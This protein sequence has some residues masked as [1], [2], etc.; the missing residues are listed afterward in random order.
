MGASA[1]VVD[2]E[3]SSARGNGVAVNALSSTTRVGPKPKRGVN[4]IGS[5]GTSNR[6]NQ[7]NFDLNSMPI[8]DGEV[9]PL[10]EQLE[11]VLD[12][13]GGTDLSEE[14]R[15]HLEAQASAHWHRLL[16]HAV[17]DTEQR[18][19]GSLALSGDVTVTTPTS[20]T[21]SVT[22]GMT[23]TTAAAATASSKYGQSPP[24]VKWDPRSQTYLR[25]T[26]TTTTTTTGGGGSGGVDGYRI[27]YGSDSGADKGKDRARDGVD[28][29]G[30]KASG[31]G[32]GNVK[33]VVLAGEEKS[34]NPNPNPNPDPD[35]D[36]DP[37]PDPDHDPD[38]TANAS[39]KALRNVG[40]KRDINLSFTSRRKRDGVEY[41]KR[42]DFPDGGSSPMSSPGTVSAATE[43]RGGANSFKA[44]A[45][46]EVEERVEIIAG[47]PTMLPA[48]E[49]SLKS[50]T[51]TALTVGWD[52][53]PIVQDALGAIRVIYRKEERS[54]TI[55]SPKS[56][57]S[58][59]GGGGTG[60]SP[61]KGTANKLPVRPL[62]TYEIAF[63]VKVQSRGA[64]ESSTEGEGE[65]EGDEWIIGSPATPLR[66]AT[67]ENLQPNTQY[68]L[69]VRR[70]GL[71]EDFSDFGVPAVIRTGPG[72]PSQP[73]DLVPSEVT[74]QSVMVSWEPPMKD[75]GL[76]VL[77]YVV[78][79]KKWG[80][81]FE[82]VYR[83]KGRVC[84]ST[85]LTPNLVHIFE[86][87]AVNKA[88]LGACG[89]RV[90]VRTLHPGAAD[91]TPW[92]EEVDERT[93]SIYYLHPK[94][95]QVA[96]TLP[97]GSLLDKSESFRSKRSYFQRRARKLIDDACHEL[98]IDDGT[99]SAKLEIPR[100][101]LLLPSLRA[102][103]RFSDDEL[104]CGPIRIKWENE[105]GIDA[106][107]LSKDWF[108]ALAKVVCN[109]TAGLLQPTDGG[110]TVDV[111]A[112][113]I[114][115]F[116]AKWIF[117][118]LGIFLS[119]ALLDTQPLGIQFNPLLLSLMC[120]KTPTMA[121]LEEGD[122]DFFKGLRW[123]LD[124]DVTGAGLSFTANYELFGVTRTVLLTENGP[125]LQDADNEV[126]GE[127][128]T[129]ENKHVYVD[130]LNHWLT[131]GKF[132][133]SLT[134]LLEGFHG[135]SPVDMLVHFSPQEVQTLLGGMP[136]I[137]VNDIKARARYMGGYSDTSPQSA[138]LWKW[139]EQADQELLGRLLAFVTGCATIPVD[140]LNP[141]FT[142]TLS[143]ETPEELA[144]WEV[145][146]ASMSSMGSVLDGTDEDEDGAE[147]KREGPSRMDSLDD[148]EQELN[149]ALYSRDS[150]DDKDDEGK[151]E[152]KGGVKE[153][154]PLMNR[155]HPP[156]ARRKLGTSKVAPLGVLPR[157]HTCF[158]QLVLPPYQTYEQ[159]S[160]QLM[161]ALDHGA[162]GFFLT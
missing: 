36:L 2:K 150:K 161:L 6:P 158:N 28:A 114:H 18:N 84:L 98:G 92:V 75:N 107:G 140:G 13:V 85:G 78:R 144:A 79:M 148:Y 100:S 53:A 160:R 138:W 47:D 46:I 60:G 113:D 38:H 67:I 64:L 146:K 91:M 86:V 27:R 126:D 4:V 102:L 68:V 32:N 122:P 134:H 154:T 80:G 118:C 99:Y 10:Y 41:K 151:G 29:T 149:S 15:R 56:S 127:L 132:E 101:D 59:A 112:G 40:S 22:G 115:G 72:P 65:G 111:R 19:L 108:C 26:A 109:G 131:R 133:P 104:R 87:Y 66:V 17:T 50:R 106:G 51:A 30:D 124:N 129:E 128:V 137:D 20:A 76:P 63:K 14:R 135:V 9:I 120:G 141:P 48:L 33:L 74:S 21:A 49:C 37:D 24:R 90:A 54:S 130:R 153:G 136:S 44:E 155:K 61:T 103:R 31:N 16:V 162:H 95:K 117:R 52:D 110:V 3:T 42:F 25:V 1:S 94:S 97:K 123:V 159:L 55:S 81:F 34:S 43:G 143:M 82:E 69:K 23:P 5:S 71:G 77:E 12:R 89:E 45:E 119:K 116:E 152:S 121:D 83:A 35:P 147:E 157:A 145:S 8:A 62:L 73:R 139:C 57:S 93:N 7:P 142:L 70:L 105:P 125:V 39:L 156:V 96:W 58:A 11:E 88:G